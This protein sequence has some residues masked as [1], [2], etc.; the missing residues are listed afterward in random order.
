VSTT[1]AQWADSPVAGFFDALH[2]DWRR[3][4]RSTAACDHALLGVFDSEIH[5]G[6]I[7]RLAPLASSCA[8]AGP[9]PMGDSIMALGR[10]HNFDIAGTGART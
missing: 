6:L 4:T 7:P 3:S 8:I 9:S 1:T 10:K 2:C 5:D